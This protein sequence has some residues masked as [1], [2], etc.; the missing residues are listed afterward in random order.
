MRCNPY[1]RKSLADI[2]RIVFQATC[3]LVDRRLANEAILSFFSIDPGG[4]GKSQAVG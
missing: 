2:F 4:R 3:P 1:G